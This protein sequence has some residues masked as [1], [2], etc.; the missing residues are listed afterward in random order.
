MPPVFRYQDLLDLIR[1]LHPGLVDV[2]PASGRQRLSLAHPS[3]SKK[4]NT[5]LQYL[6][7][8]IQELS[9]QFPDIDVFSDE[10]P[11]STEPATVTMAEKILQFFTGGQQPVPTPVAQSFAI[12]RQGKLSAQSFLTAAELAEFADLDRAHQEDKEAVR[13]AGQSV[14][15]GSSISAGV[16]ETREATNQYIAGLH[17][18]HRLN[19]LEKTAKFR[20]DMSFPTIAA[21]ISRHDVSDDGKLR[22]L[23]QEISD[24]DVQAIVKN[25]EHAL[26]MEV[27]RRICRRFGLVPVSVQR[28]KDGEG[29][30]EDEVSGLLKPG[31]VLMKPIRDYEINPPEGY[32]IHVEPEAEVAKIPEE[33]G[34]FNA[35]RYAA[36]RTMRLYWL[37]RN[38]NT[39]TDCLQRNQQE[40]PK[41]FKDEKAKEEVDGRFLNSF[42]AIEKLKIDLLGEVLRRMTLAWTGRASAHVY[43]T[44]EGRKIDLSFYSDTMRSR[45]ESGKVRYRLVRQSKLKSKGLFDRSEAVAEEV[46]AALA[47]L[48]MD[49]MR[50]LQK[51]LNANVPEASDLSTS[52]LG[53]VIVTIKNID[54]DGD[55]KHAYKNLLLSAKEIQL[56]QDFLRGH[57]AVKLADKLQQ[58]EQ[59]IEYVM[60]YG[61]VFPE[62]DI[63]TYESVGASTADIFVVDRIDLSAAVMRFFHTN[64]ESFIAAH[65]TSSDEKLHLA[66]Q[67]FR[68]LLDQIRQQVIAVAQMVTLVD[69]SSIATLSSSSDPAI[70]NLFQDAAF[71]ISLRILND[72]KT[73]QPDQAQPARD[74]AIK[75]ILDSQGCNNLIF[76]QEGR[77]R[78]IF[79][80]M[81]EHVQTRFQA[82][83]EEYSRSKGLGESLK[84]ACDTLQTELETYIHGSSALGVP[85]LQRCV[86]EGKPLIYAE[87]A[88]RLDTQIL[89]FWRR[90]KDFKSSGDEKIENTAKLVKFMQ[91]LV[92]NIKTHAVV[93]LVCEEANPKWSAYQEERF[94]KI[95]AKEYERLK[96]RQ[97]LISRDEDSAE[98]L[99]E[100]QK[101]LQPEVLKKRALYLAKCA[102]IEVELL[103]SPVFKFIGE[104]ETRL[105]SQSMSNLI[106]FLRTI[107]RL[108]PDHYQTQCKTLVNM[109]QICDVSAEVTSAHLVL[110]ADLNACFPSRAEQSHEKSNQSVI[111][112]VA[113]YFRNYIF[114]PRVAAGLPEFNEDNLNQCSINQW[115][116]QFLVK[117]GGEH[118]T[119]IH[120]LTS[121]AV[122]TDERYRHMEK[123][124]QKLGIVVPTEDDKVFFS[125]T[126]PEGRQ[127]IPLC[128]G[129]VWAAA[130][131]LKIMYALRSTDQELSN[132]HQ[133]QLALY[134]EKIAAYVRKVI[135]AYFTHAIHHQS[136]PE[137]HHHYVR[138]FGDPVTLVNFAFHTVQ[139]RL[140]H[141]D[142]DSNIA[143]NWIPG[144]NEAVNLSDDYELLWTC[145]HD[146]TYRST[147][148]VPESSSG[149]GNAENTLYRRLNRYLRECIEQRGML[150]YLPY[151]TGSNNREIDVRFVLLV[152][153]FGD[154]A[155]NEYMHKQ[156]LEELYHAKPR[157]SAGRER[158]ERVIVAYKMQLVHFFKE[159][160]NQSFKHVGVN[161]TS[162]LSKDA[163]LRNESFYMKL[164]AAGDV[165]LNKLLTDSLLVTSANIS[166]ED[167]VT[168]NDF[169]SSEKQRL[170]FQCFNFSAVFH[171]IDDEQFLRSNATY[172]RFNR[173]AHYVRLRRDIDAGQ[174]IRAARLPMINRI[175]ENIEETEFFARL[176]NFLY[177]RFLRL[178]GPLLSHA[179]DFIPQRAFDVLTLLF[180]DVGNEY[181]KFTSLDFNQYSVKFSGK[182]ITTSCEL[183]DRA[184]T[185]RATAFQKAFRKVA[186]LQEHIDLKENG[187]EKYADLKAQI[188][189]CISSCSGGG[190]ATAKQFLEMLL[191]YYKYQISRLISQKDIPPLLRSNLIAALTLVLNSIGQVSNQKLRAVLSPYQ[192]K[193]GSIQ[194]I[195]SDTVFRDRI[196][197]IFQNAQEMDALSTD[198]LQQSFDRTGGVNF[199]AAQFPDAKMGW[200]WAY[201]AFPT[202]Y[203]MHHLT[204]E[205]ASAIHDCVLFSSV[206]TPVIRWY[207]RWFEQLQQY[208]HEDHPYVRSLVSFIYIA[209]HGTKG[210]G[211]VHVRY[212]EIFK[213]VYPHFCSN[214]DQHLFS[215]Y[216]GEQ[217]TPPIGMISPAYKRD[218]EHGHMA[219]ALIQD[220]IMRMR[221]V[222]GAIKDKTYPALINYI[223]DKSV[224]VVCLKEAE[225]FNVLREQ[226]NSVYQD[227]MS[228][229]VSLITD[230]RLAGLGERWPMYYRG[231]ISVKIHGFFRE[232]E[233]SYLGSLTSGRRGPWD[234]ELCVDARKTQELIGKCKEMKR[235]L[236][237][238]GVKNNLVAVRFSLFRFFRLHLMSMIEENLSLE[239][240]SQR[241]MNQTNDKAKIV[242]WLTILGRIVFLF[243]ESR[244]QQWLKARLRELKRFYYLQL[245]QTIQ[246]HPH[247]P[248][249]TARVNVDIIAEFLTQFADVLD[250]R[251]L[252]LLEEKRRRADTEED[253]QAVR[254]EAMCLHV[255][256]PL[257]RDGYSQCLNNMHAFFL[258]KY[259]KDLLPLVLMDLYPQET[260]APINDEQAI[261]SQHEHLIKFWK[262]IILA[263]REHVAH[264]DDQPFVY[265]Y[266]RV[267]KRKGQPDSV[268]LVGRFVHPAA[269]DLYQGLQEAVNNDVITYQQKEAFDDALREETHRSEAIAHS[270]LFP[271]QYE[272][273]LHFFYL[274]LS[275]SYTDYHDVI[276]QAEAEPCFRVQFLSIDFTPEIKK[277]FKRIVSYLQVSR[278]PIDYAVLQHVCDERSDKFSLTQAERDLVV[279]ISQYVRGHLPATDHSVVTGSL[280]K[281]ASVL[282]LTQEDLNKLKTLQVHLKSKKD[283]EPH[284]QVVAAL[285]ECPV[286]VERSLPVDV[287]ERVKD[288]GSYLHGNAVHGV[289][290]TLLDKIQKHIFL[291]NDD[292]N[293]LDALLE[294]LKS[295]QPPQLTRV[296]L[297]KDLLAKDKKTREAQKEG[298]Q[299][300]RLT[301]VERRQ[302]TDMSAHL[303]EIDAAII[304]AEIVNKLS[305]VPL[306]GG[307]LV[308]T[309]TDE[310]AIYQM[311][312][313][314]QNAKA[315]VELTLA[316]LQKRQ[317]AQAKPSS[318]RQRVIL[319]NDEQVEVKVIERYLE[320]RGIKKF[321]LIISKL[322]STQGVESFVRPDVEFIESMQRLLNA[323]IPTSR[324]LTENLLEKYAQE[325]AQK[326]KIVLSDDDRASIQG[327]QAYFHNSSYQP[328][329]AAILTKIVSTASQ[330]NLV[331]TRADQHLVMLI[332]RVLKSSGATLNYN[333]LERLLIPARP[334]ALRLTAGEVREITTMHEEFHAARQAGSM[335]LKERR[336]FQE[337][338]VRLQDFSRHLEQYFERSTIVTIVDYFMSCCAGWLPEVVHMLHRLKN[339]AGDEILLTRAEQRIVLALNQQLIHSKADFTTWLTAKSTTL[340]VEACLTEFDHFAQATWHAA[341]EQKVFFDESV[342][343]KSNVGLPLLAKV[344]IHVKHALGEAGETH[345]KKIYEL[346]QALREGLMTLQEFYR[347][348]IWPVGFLERRWFTP[349]RQGAVEATP[350]VNQGEQPQ[351][352]TTRRQLSIQP[353]LRRLDAVLREL[354]GEDQEFVLAHYEGLKNV[355][356]LEHKLPFEQ[357]KNNDPKN[358]ASKRVFEL[359]VRTKL[360]L[361]LFNP[362]EIYFQ[363][364]FEIVRLIKS[365]AFSRAAFEMRAM[366]ALL[367][368]RLISILENWQTIAP[369]WVM[370]YLTPKLMLSALPKKPGDFEGDTSEFEQELREY[371]AHCELFSAY[372][373]LPEDG[374]IADLRS[375]LCMLF[376]NFFLVNRMRLINPH[377]R[378]L[379]N[380]S[381]DIFYITNQGELQ[382]FTHALQY[383]YVINEQSAQ[384]LKTFVG[385]LQDEIK[386][387]KF[388]TYL[389]AFNEKTRDEIFSIL[390]TQ[391]ADPI[392]HERLNDE[393]VSTTLVQ[394]MHTSYVSAVQTEYDSA[395]SY[396]ST[397]ADFNFKIR[398]LEEQ[399][400]IA[401]LFYCY[402]Q[403]LR[404]CFRAGDQG[405][406]EAKCAAIN[407][408]EANIRRVIFQRKVKGVLQSIVST[409]DYLQELTRLI[410]QASR[411]G[412]LNTS[413]NLTALKEHLNKARNPGEMLSIMHIIQKL[414]WILWVKEGKKVLPFISLEEILEIYRD[415]GQDDNA[416]NERAI[417]EEE[418]E[419]FL[420]RLLQQGHFSAAREELIAWMSVQY[421][422]KMPTLHM[423]HLISSLELGLKKVSFVADTGDALI[424]DT[425]N[426]KQVVVIPRAEWSKERL[427]RCSLLELLV[428]YQQEYPESFNENISEQDLVLEGID[429]EKAS[430]A[431][432][433]V[434]ATKPFKELTFSPPEHSFDELV[435]AIYISRQLEI[436][437]GQHNISSLETMGWVKTDQGVYVVSEEELATLHQDR[438]ELKLTYA[439]IP[440]YAVARVALAIRQRYENLVFNIATLPKKRDSLKLISSPFM[441]G[442]FLQAMRC[443][444]SCIARFKQKLE[445]GLRELSKQVFSTGQDAVDA[446]SPYSRLAQVFVP[447]APLAK[448][449]DGTEY[450]DYER[451]ALLSRIYYFGWFT[452]KTWEMA[453]SIDQALRLNIIDR[454]TSASI[455]EREQRVHAITLNLNTE[456]RGIQV[457]FAKFLS[458]LGVIASL[459]TDQQKEIDEK[460]RKQLEM[461]P[462][463]VQAR[464]EFNES[465]ISLFA[466]VSVPGVGNFKGKFSDQRSCPL[467]VRGLLAPK[468]KQQAYVTL[469][470]QEKDEELNKILGQ[471]KKLVYLWTELEGNGGELRLVKECGNVKA[472]DIVHLLKLKNG[473]IRELEEP[474]ECP[475]D[476]RKPLYNSSLKILGELL[477]E[478]V[479]EGIYTSSLLVKNT[480]RYVKACLARAQAPMSKEEYD[481]L[482]VE[483]RT[484]A[485]IFSTLRAIR[486]RLLTVVSNK[487]EKDILMSMNLDLDALPVCISSSP[488][489]ESKVTTSAD[490]TDD[491]ED[492]AEDAEDAEDDVEDAVLLPEVL[493]ETDDDL[494]IPKVEGLEPILGGDTFFWD[495]LTC[496]LGESER[497]LIDLLQTPDTMC[498]ITQARLINLRGTQ[499]THRQRESLIRRIAEFQLSDVEISIVLQILAEK[500]GRNIVI[501]SQE[502]GQLRCLYADANIAQRYTNP[503]VFLFR[504]TGREYGYYQK[505]N[506]TKYA[507]LLARLSLSR[508]IH[509]QE[510]ELQQQQTQAFKCVIPHQRGQQVLQK[511]SPPGS[512]VLVFQPDLESWLTH[513][514]AINR[515]LFANLGVLLEQESAEQKDYLYQGLCVALQGCTSLRGRHQAKPNVQELI[516]FLNDEWSK[517]G[518]ENL[519]E[520]PVFKNIHF[521]ELLS[522]KQQSHIRERFNAFLRA[523][524]VIF[525]R[526]LMA[527]TNDPEVQ[528]MLIKMLPHFIR[529]EIKE[530]RRFLY[531]SSIAEWRRIWG[532]I[533]REEIA[534]K[535]K[536]LVARRAELT[537]EGQILSPD[538]EQ[539]LSTAQA[540]LDAQDTRDSS[541]VS[542]DAAAL[543]DAIDTHIFVASLSRAEEN[544]F[545]RAHP[546]IARQVNGNAVLERMGVESIFKRN[547]QD[548]LASYAADSDVQTVFFT[549]LPS[550][551]REETGLGKQ[552]LYRL[553]MHA[554]EQIFKDRLG[555]DADSSPPKLDRW[556][557]PDNLDEDSLTPLKSAKKVLKKELDELPDID[558]ES[559]ASLL[560]SFIIAQREK[561]VL[562]VD[563]LFWKELVDQLDLQV[564]FADYLAGYDADILLPG[565]ICLFFAKKYGSSVYIFTY[566]A[567]DRRQ[568]KSIQ[569]HQSLELSES[570]SRPHYL[571]LSADGRYTALALPSTG[572]AL[573]GGAHSPSSVTIASLSRDSSSQSVHALFKEKMV[574]YYDPSTA[575]FTVHGRRTQ[576]ALS[577][578]SSAASSM[579]STQSSRAGSQYSSTRSSRRSS[580]TAS[581]VATPGMGSS[582]QN[583]EEVGDTSIVTTIPTLPVLTKENISSINSEITAF[584]SGG[585]SR[586][587]LFASLHE[588]FNPEQP[589]QTRAR[590]LFGHSQ[591]RQGAEGLRDDYVRYVTHRYLSVNGGLKQGVTKSELE[592]LV[593]LLSMID[594]ALLRS[595]YQAFVNKELESDDARREIEGE[596]VTV[597]DLFS[598]LHESFNSKQLL[599]TKARYLFGDSA[600]A[601]QLKEDYLKYAANTYE[602]GGLSAIKPLI[603][604]LH[605]LAYDWLLSL[606][607]ETI[608]NEVRVWMS[609]RLVDQDKDMSASALVQACGDYFR[610]QGS[611][612][613]RQLHKSFNPQDFMATEARYLFGNAHI[614]AVKIFRISYFNYVRMHYREFELGSISALANLLKETNPDLLVE[615]YKETSAF[616][617]GA[618]KVFFKDI[619]QLEVYLRIIVHF[620]KGCGV[621]ES[622][623]EEVRLA[624]V[625]HC[626]PHIHF[627]QALETIKKQILP[628]IPKDQSSAS[629]QVVLV[630]SQAD[631]NYVQL[632]FDIK[633]MIARLDQNIAQL[634]SIIEEMRLK[635]DTESPAAAA[636]TSA[637]TAIV[638]VDQRAVVHKFFNVDCSNISAIALLEFLFAKS[639][640]EI[641]CY[642]EVK[643]RTELLY[644]L[645]VDAFSI[646]KN[647]DDF[648]TEEKLQYMR[649]FL[650]K[651]IEAVCTYVESN[652]FKVAFLELLFRQLMVKLNDWQGVLTEY[653]KVEFLTTVFTTFMQR[654]R[655]IDSELKM[656]VCHRLFLEVLGT[657][658]KELSSTLQQQII[659]LRQL[660]ASVSVALS[661]GSLTQIASYLK[662]QL[663]E[664][665]KILQQQKEGVVSSMALLVNQCEREFAST[666]FRE[667]RDASLKRGQAESIVR[668]CLDQSDFRV[669][670]RTEL[671]RAFARYLAEKQATDIDKDCL[672]ILRPALDALIAGH[673]TQK[674]RC[675]LE[676]F[677]MSVNIIYKHADDRINMKQAYGYELLTLSTDILWQ[678]DGHSVEE[679]TTLLQALQVASQPSEEAVDSADFSLL[680]QLQSVIYHPQLAY[681]VIFAEGVKIL[682]SN[683]PFAFILLEN[684]SKIL[685]EPET[686]PSLL[687]NTV[688]ALIEQRHLSAQIECH[689][690]VDL[691]GSI[692]GLLRR[693]WNAEPD[694]DSY[695]YDASNLGP[696]QAGLAAVTRLDKL[697]LSAK[698]RSSTSRLFDSS[699]VRSQNQELAQ[700]LKFL[701]SKGE[702]TA[703]D[704]A[705]YL[706]VLVQQGTPNALYVKYVEAYPNICILDILS[707]MM[708]SL[709]HMIKAQQ[710]PV[711]F[712]TEIFE[713]MRWLERFTVARISVSSPSKM[714][715]TGWSALKDHAESQGFKIVDVSADGN[716]FFHAVI[717]QIHI[718]GLSEKLDTLRIRSHR[719]LRQQVCVYMQKKLQ[720]RNDYTNLSETKMRTYIQQLQADGAWAE[721]QIIDAT[722]EMLGV[723]IRIFTESNSC[724]EFTIP[725]PQAKHTIV[726]ANQG[727]SH[728]QSVESSNGQT[729]AA[730]REAGE[731]DA[732]RAREEQEKVA[733]MAG[734]D[735]LAALDAI[736]G[737][738][739]EL[740]VTLHKKDPCQGPSDEHTTPF[741]IMQTILL[742]G[743]LALL[744]TPEQPSVLVEAYRA[745]EQ[746]NKTL[747]FEVFNLEKEVLPLASLKEKLID[748]LRT[749]QT[750]RLSVQ[751]AVSIDVDL[752]VPKLVNGRSLF[753]G[754]SS[755]SSS[756]RVSD[757][758]PGVGP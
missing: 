395:I 216:K 93:T 348:S 601:L 61:V 155:T 533:K 110:E 15:K 382:Q 333:V 25:F 522:S 294:H 73:M 341:D 241:L 188:A 487:A 65:Q 204:V 595:L 242:N 181:R 684:A 306:T 411:D 491:E 559:L 679:R 324:Q 441:I 657:I 677:Q 689:H 451:H 340:S 750:F 625:R 205:I 554:F 321:D 569:L 140:G 351:M 691:K 634:F 651:G 428:I 337:A 680:R 698:A 525:D 118:L 296:A 661:S 444:D 182:Q 119:W 716:C 498:K 599:A 425:L 127:R 578:E 231:I 8:L 57:A 506:D 184:L 584:I 412:R 446:F 246:T 236:S 292:R 117:Y 415:L 591:G 298:K 358:D 433:S 194:K 393:G 239:I 566:D 640:E 718:L 109:L 460:Q 208:F 617:L 410:E 697:A 374:S 734:L 478:K 326:Q 30:L 696:K 169:D 384:L 630:S 56:F 364:A 577:R 223:F 352:M 416:A 399:D 618:G 488:Q 276:Q 512:A 265:S 55:T 314:W 266:H 671:C 742:E 143:Y 46:S 706:R 432:M 572:T 226:Y 743:M 230:E 271:Y 58:I 456:Y 125:A 268:R 555:L 391:L 670:V 368:P 430:L 501:I 628:D 297:V 709:N 453:C 744:G 14:A 547:I 190:E 452:S 413:Q 130:N 237:H 605:C 556:R 89:D 708:Q 310:E 528:S 490:S 328:T 402:A 260:H 632:F 196:L 320:Q 645:T 180:K 484:L 161:E 431:N 450:S 21:V 144:P 102:N 669:E 758:L 756:D 454:L 187:Q 369:E 350:A 448:K 90:V 531:D 218:S 546:A 505:A 397:D 42:L 88:R 77:S 291:S 84:T 33:E 741:R 678:Q 530:G 219:W 541:I 592:S 35:I 570:T 557:L 128:N 535:R 573:V 423:S 123:Y 308:L 537:A 385:I 404:I 687:V 682:S 38:I 550:L 202:T 112:D 732:L 387:K 137:I 233:T 43:S 302:I 349:I 92:E 755:P 330:A 429:V 295:Q 129:Q 545:L 378:V 31:H 138:A 299:T 283:T 380:I 633:S 162:S 626:F 480:Q 198:E 234:H 752:A 318:E 80:L 290:S 455:D 26:A 3:L 644:G 325:R 674:G 514:P 273:W 476:W 214:N 157:T 32:A 16:R 563:Y 437:F 586:E 41:S 248:S 287:L 148:M 379:S 238:P 648:S 149:Q 607:R 153:R 585:E 641:T 322:L 420:M 427:R 164:A 449:K 172:R 539:E 658:S 264:A 417:I 160:F 753:A 356:T 304:F 269:Y 672:E 471:E 536:A 521:L 707:K 97:S 68:V 6:A 201:G 474:F 313:M 152:F 158:V 394:F 67:R 497:G 275:K 688:L 704:F 703:E 122:V 728:F 511:V 210:E 72:F 47:Q 458:S 178:E 593:P 496:A 631:K 300:I 40:L 620:G 94:N 284:L 603:P 228:Q 701:G 493:S 508:V 167:D 113:L 694:D 665:M 191:D 99:D 362:Q 69:T 98:E 146:S 481:D 464:H 105:T 483:Y 342:M 434:V 565:L 86:Q 277:A 344:P 250:I 714:K 327:I 83:K 354:E 609:A 419:Y 183:Y 370:Y 509:C 261:R 638:P 467:R 159:E 156:L 44:V 666:D 754:P 315:L 316:L 472:L 475:T 251:A 381:E 365:T 649:S 597:G 199:T 345:P 608:D 323:C 695:T 329:F 575:R 243:G 403:L 710:I 372:A 145:L 693:Y 262:F 17:P 75:S 111:Q 686:G 712:R 221:S 731:R 502:K 48:S 49:E 615:L 220:V 100:L 445:M 637:E 274:L 278:A 616:L 470:E 85:S 520:H 553:L 249:Q 500:F 371:L 436:Q 406:I 1:S 203:F 286:D 526:G 621:A 540:E 20:S 71:W 74:L 590:L 465:I 439:D 699:P 629:T 409:E 749:E 494:Y 510:Q 574:F 519:R 738:L 171:A 656:S 549:M 447:L 177:E 668:G 485:N 580:K 729:A 227:L 176:C 720:D 82:F 107:S 414:R 613:A 34:A 309:Q 193:L 725:V 211:A 319:T 62:A 635:A 331:L 165:L 495:V 206:A 254:Q 408:G 388:V 7:E 516:R 212:L 700:A 174:E 332:Q 189:S 594:S 576:E 492:D 192:R 301:V 307:S 745:L 141:S 435:Q 232:I 76:E 116:I 663:V 723:N 347:F 96:A 151:K 270:P 421:T 473:Q 360:A 154:E 343:R 681:G 245:S 303:A 235:I 551:L 568:C 515:L 50:Q 224:A 529:E 166:T 747:C 534:E 367:A 482:A 150:H 462:A 643:R 726:L 87:V 748:I 730:M 548:T 673:A 469:L 571:L 355:L 213:D 611:Q 108:Y 602:K 9:R 133:E 142:R 244:D 717:R 272:L 459:I 54:L 255:N 106:G 390:A 45:Y 186:E 19:M 558:E 376:E 5:D 639:L 442:K 281:G 604:L 10:L 426:P 70:L 124:A 279:Q 702:K 486:S 179:G 311:H 185:V 12:S 373:L 503:V 383:M 675:L 285:L 400:Q 705:H 624:A 612:F 499:L 27:R 542:L 282:A 11:N 136:L 440:V 567:T 126:N 353:A 642:P 81:C 690:L 711:F 147:S 727:S 131:T 288:L 659:W 361:S 653:E 289:I 120:G 23:P 479:E 523:R 334:Q 209:Q 736:S 660:Y 60:P 489:A 305:T 600:E 132:R 636:S 463:L 312:V 59:G 18:R 195:L 114:L 229:N 733:N 28:G 22:S 39:V 217:F 258:G 405:G 627:A 466:L 654:M 562:G 646:V 719:E 560:E 207:Q 52:V 424:Q 722:A 336:E 739:N 135:A 247:S 101:L 103:F 95:Y 457:A 477:Y 713:F 517:I 652:D 115:A 685:I 721:G 163:Y 513:Y 598:H 664:S 170:L 401:S 139:Y 375:R 735:Y 655:L 544:A 339:A 91:L 392:F 377:F 173:L 259:R 317:E 398:F 200:I 662:K 2:D 581:Q 606:Y 751:Q 418:V 197:I 746:Y 335:G 468:S 588:S 692:V 596:K 78:F 63:P 64:I 24:A 53:S 583:N 461:T 338:L 622:D 13:E 363:R 518:Y 614:V 29:V 438:K 407:E 737:E 715:Q 623:I 222:P 66:A 579:V 225:T 724:P 619:S 532:A 257:C 552:V 650:D 253:H 280:L 359:K 443:L 667:M 587:R 36:Y 267:H 422:A 538:L 589:M 389:K 683:R 240:F 121:V 215:I 561:Q 524:V 175:G 51:V 346:M 740:L 647:N 504:R 256:A 263:I 357:P 757:S 396:P 676:L 134:R 610:Q 507:D 564:L 4:L 582:P 37:L 252:S 527:C 543:A 168:I 79:D 386:L 366:R 293:G 104:N